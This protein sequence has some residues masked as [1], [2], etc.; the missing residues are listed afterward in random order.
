MSRLFA[1]L[2]A[3]LL[4]LLLAAPATAID[5][6]TTLRA[7][8]FSPMRIAPDFS[9]RG[10]DGKIFKLSQYR[11]KVVLL[12]FGYTHCMAVCPITLAVLAGAHRK[13]GAAGKDLQV[14]YVTVDPERDNAARMK[15]F[16]GSFDPTFMGGTGTVAQVDAVRKDYGISAVKVPMAEGYMMSHSSFVYLIDRDGKLRALMP[17]GHS[18]DDY[19]HDTSILLKH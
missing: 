2:T 8:S 14:V 5:D 9:L 13:L 4:A 3:L 7:G 16:L 19:V 17:Y 18:I 1:P 6:S 10:S 11:G 15:E 12:S